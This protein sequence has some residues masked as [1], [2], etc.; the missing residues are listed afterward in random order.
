MINHERLLAIH[1][2]SHTLAFQRPLYKRV[3]KPGI[4]DLAFVGFAPALPTLL[5]VV[6]WQS[7]RAVRPAHYG[8]SSSSIS[9][10]AATRASPAPGLM[11]AVT[12]S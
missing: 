7:R 3:F 9:P 10:A 6:E 11:R 8:F 5:P 4:D 1:E 2:L 12:T